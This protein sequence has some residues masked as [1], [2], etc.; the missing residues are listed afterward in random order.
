M[1]ETLRI[2]LENLRKQREIR[3]ISIARGIKEINHSL[4]AYNTLLIGGAS[5]LITRRFKR[6]LD[7]FLAVLWGFLNK[8]KCRNTWNVSLQ[9][10][11]RISLIMDISVQRNWS[12]FSYLGLPLAKEVVKS[13]IWNKQIEK[14]RGHLQSW[15]LSWLNL[16]GRAI[17]IKALLSAL[18]IYQYVVT[19]APASIHK[20]MELIMRGFLWQEGKQDTKKFSLV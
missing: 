11:Q 13:E 2:N 1:A 14:M 12:H 3:G 6:I 20:Q 18:P 5:R 15:G 4:F 19:L 17:L 7:T 9:V 8:K 10:M 16:V